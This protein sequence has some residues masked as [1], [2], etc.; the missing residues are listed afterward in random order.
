MRSIVAGA[1]SEG[2]V[3]SCEHAAVAWALD[4]DGVVWLGDQPIPGAT[5]AV[6]RLQA[7]GEPV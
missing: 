7:S 2:A 1:G 6:G 3:R 4:L 5:E